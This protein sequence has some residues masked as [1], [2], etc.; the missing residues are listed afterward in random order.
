M[1]KRFGQELGYSLVEVMVSIVLLS[2]AIVPM[3]SMFDV[4]LETATRGGNYDKARAFATERVERAK[5]LPYTDVKNRFPVPSSAP[6][7]GGTYT[8]GVLNVPED[9]GLPA[10]SNYTVR[11]QYVRV[12]PQPGTASGTPAPLE[13]A[14]NDTRMMRVTVSVNWLG[15]SAPD[16][17]SSGFVSRSIS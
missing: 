14:T 11:K 16:F 3:I 9:A 5:V 2:V 10:G 13:N 17:T 15:G 4:G 8:S 12:Q 7:G 1:A 6:G